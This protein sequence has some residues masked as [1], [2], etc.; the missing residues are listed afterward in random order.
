MSRHPHTINI[1]LHIGTSPVTSPYSIS[2][3]NQN[4]GF[5]DRIQDP[6]HLMKLPD[7]GGVCMRNISAGKLETTSCEKVRNERF[8]EARVPLVYHLHRPRLTSHLNRLHQRVHPQADRVPLIKS[9]NR[10]RLV[11]Q[12][13]HSSIPPLQHHKC[14]ISLCR[15]MYLT[16]NPHQDPLNQRWRLGTLLEPRPLRIL[17]RKPKTCPSQPM[18][19]YGISH[20]IPMNR[21]GFPRREAHFPRDW[22]TVLLHQRAMIS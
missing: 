12:I 11:V 15:P 2:L 4:L 22:I 5:N 6:G 21:N 3:A 8:I 9:R 18:N 20:L 14:Q 17:N 16:K 1:P 7:A 19:L 10:S 13:L